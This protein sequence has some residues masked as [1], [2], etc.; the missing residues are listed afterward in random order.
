MGAVAHPEDHGNEYG[1]GGD[2]DGNGGGGVHA[3]SIGRTPP[4]TRDPI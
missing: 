2:A 3:S 1:E 4:L